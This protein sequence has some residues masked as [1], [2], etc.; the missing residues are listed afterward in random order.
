MLINIITCLVLSYAVA[1]IIKRSIHILSSSLWTK[2][3]L[4]AY[5]CSLFGEKRKQGGEPGFPSG[6]MALAGCIFYFMFKQRNLFSNIIGILVV[7]FMF[8]D[9]TMTKNACHTYT[10]AVGGFALGFL[11]SHITMKYIIKHTL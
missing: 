8:F 6:H 7:C 10:Q 1:S 5:G 11:I 9:R 2:R 4:N 3:P